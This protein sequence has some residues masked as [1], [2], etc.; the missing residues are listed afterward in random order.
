MAETLLDVV[1][2]ILRVS[3]QNPSKTT[4]SDSDDT[5][6]VVDRI[7]EALKWIYSKNPTV[8]DTHSGITLPPSTR[9]VAVPAGVDIYKIYDWSFRI[10]G[11][12]DIA[13]EVVSLEFITNH[14]ENFETE[15]AEK[16]SFVYLD[17]GQLGF[18][19]MVAAGSASKTIQFIYPALNSRLNSVSSTFPFPDE[20]DEIFYC[21]KYAQ[22][23][24]ELYKGLGQPLDTANEV[25]SLKARLSARY[26]RNKRIGFKPYRIYA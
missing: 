17:G 7:N 12:P 22:Y 13:L 10:N 14:F 25:T 4:F 6:W 15:E 5:Q 20:S 11:T 21:E 9:R 8:V 26:A 16:P 24:Y 1:K 18:Y 3:G 2:R 23:R 19:P